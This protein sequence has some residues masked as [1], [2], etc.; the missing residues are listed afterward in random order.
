MIRDPDA[1]RAPLF[2]LKTTRRLPCRL[3]QKRVRPRRAR[4]QKAELPSIYFRVSGNLCEV[5]AHQSEM[6]VFVG[7]SN[8]TNTLKR[9]LVAN[10]TAE[11]VTR[12]CRVRDHPAI[13]DDIGRL[14]Y[15]TLL[16]IFWMEPEPLHRLMIAI[17]RPETL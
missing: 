11:G 17:L 9:V 13:T 2:V 4:F 10:V 16:R 14:S 12:V 1:D 7:L 5:S 3:E 6:M 8:P 15:E